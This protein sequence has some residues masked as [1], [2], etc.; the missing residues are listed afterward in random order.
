MLQSCQRGEPYRMRRYCFRRIRREHPAGCWRID[1]AS[2]IEITAEA[3]HPTMRVHSDG[4]PGL[5]APLRRD[6][7]GFSADFGPFQFRILSY[8]DASMANAC[9]HFTDTE[10]G[11]SDEP[12]CADYLGLTPEL[13]Y[14][15]T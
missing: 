9:I 3:T 8:I 7:K 15:R 5:C 11:D 2:F 14:T 6:D 12:F 10:P 4:T 1:D 13:A